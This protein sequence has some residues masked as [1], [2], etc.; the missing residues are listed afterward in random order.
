[1]PTSPSRKPGIKPAATKPPA[2]ATGKRILRPLLWFAALV[3][4]A[5]VVIALPASMVRRFLPSAVA[6]DDFSGS[7]W[8]GSAGSITLGGQNVGALEWHLSP[9]PLF[10][11]NL[12]ADL[13]WVKMGFVADG[14]VTLNAHEVTL[15]NLQGGGPIED[16][17]DLGIAP[18]WH[19]AADFRFSE[20]QASFGG[21]ALGGTAGR[22]AVTLHSAVGDV[23]LTDLAS[24]AIAHG[25]D[26]GGYTLHV[27]EPRLAPGADAAAEL[28]D[29]GG[30]LEVRA[31]IHL[32][33]NGHSGTLSGTVKARA[34]APPPVRTQ[35]DQLAE[36][37]A[38]DAQGRIPVDLEFTL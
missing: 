19:G 33:A 17:H 27:A 10:A 2:T 7:V 8:H 25:V 21:G 36:L 24:P 23:R 16:L 35:L 26:L 38:P 34:D 5:V 3:A 18:G 6:A 9:W 28:S 11:L 14:T 12:V 13:H 1:M 31:T 15:R 29:A 32:A 20:V 30:P 4:L 22:G 37:H